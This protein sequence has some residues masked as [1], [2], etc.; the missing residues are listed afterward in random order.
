MTTAPNFSSF[1]SPLV[2]F[3]EHGIDYGGAAIVVLTEL[4]RSAPPWMQTTGCDV[5]AEASSSR[6]CRY[7]RREAER[8]SID[9][10]SS[11]TPL[12]L[13]VGHTGQATTSRDAALVVA[14]LVERRPAVAKKT[15][16]GIESIVRNA[17]LAIEAG[18]LAAVGQL[19]DM[20]QMLLAG[21]FVSDSDIEAMCNVAR[22]VGACGAK[23][24]GGRSGCVVALTETPARRDAVL[25][26]WQA[27]GLAGIAATAFGREVAS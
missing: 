19:L 11:R 13:C 22:A 14:R 3:G 27:R 17:R 8:L 1:D 20:N 25:E 21:L 5:L 18:D 6:A 12:Y 15:F 16:E 9:T 23:I 26:A 2:L 10:F 4:A 7:L 24:T